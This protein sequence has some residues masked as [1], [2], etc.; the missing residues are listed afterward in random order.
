MSVQTY[1]NKT[2]SDMYYRLQNLDRFTDFIYIPKDVLSLD[3][4]EDD[5]KIIYHE[6]KDD[7][8][9][10][11]DIINS[12]P[13]NCNIYNWVLPLLLNCPEHKPT[14]TLLNLCFD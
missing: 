14:R 8:Y 13:T 12:I 4:S 3:T 6:K 1:I 9:E 2:S 5:N 10:L 11:C 7:T